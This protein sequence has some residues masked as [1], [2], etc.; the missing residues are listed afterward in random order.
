[1]CLSV[2]LP[3][4][5]EIIKSFDF[6]AQHFSIF[7]PIVLFLQ[8]ATLQKSLS[9]LFLARA[10]SKTALKTYYTWPAPHSRQSQWL[11]SEHSKA[12]SKF[13]KRKGKK[14]FDIRQVATN[15]LR[16]LHVYSMCSS[17]MFAN[18]LALSTLNEHNMSNICVAFSLFCPLVAKKTKIKL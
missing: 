2:D 13:A 3:F 10:F 5:A 8:H 12:W 9:N 16:L 7:Q 4:R 11:A 1:M 17:A 14:I 6:T 18:M 15:T